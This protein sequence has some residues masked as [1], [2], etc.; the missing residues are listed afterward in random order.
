MSFI[1]ITALPVGSGYTLF[2]LDDQDKVWFYKDQQR[3]W[4]E[5]SE[6]PRE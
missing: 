1:S 4:I 6:L 3:Q 2:A 5:H